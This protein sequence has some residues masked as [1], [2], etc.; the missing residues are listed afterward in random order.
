M[1]NQTTIGILGDGQL[2][3]MMAQAAKKINFELD[4]I[5]T[6]KL[7]CYGSVRTSPASYESDVFNGNYDD[8]ELLTK[9]LAKNSI[10][11]YETENINLTK[12]KQILSE[13]NLKPNIEILTTAQNRL[14]EKKMLNNLNIE[15]TEY[16]P[17]ES[18]E[19][20]KKASK[21]F[22]YKAILKTCT[23][24][25][26]GKGQF[27]INNPNSI[28][29]IW[30]SALKQNLTQKSNQKSNQELEINT[31]LI[32]E[33]LVEFNQELSI[34][35]ARDINNNIKFYPLTKNI[36]Q[37]GIL[38]LSLAP[39]QYLSSNLNQSKLLERQAQIIIAKIL[40]HFDYIGILCV[41]FFQ[42]G[43]KLV[44]N[45]IA[46][47]VHNSGHWTIEGAKTS[48]FENHLRAISGMPLGDTSTVT[49]SNTNIYSAMFNFIS[50]IPTLDK[51]EVI[52]NLVNSNSNSKSNNIYIH[53]YKKLPRA[54][55]KLGHM[56]IC[57]ENKQDLYHI[58]EQVQQIL[59]LNL[60][61]T[62]HK[63]L[64]IHTDIQTDINSEKNQ[65]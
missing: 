47:R 8:L 56:N 45:E 52:K 10:L 28:E 50:K 40:Q 18:L 42:V 60:N 24:G 41:E 44:V 53:D 11:T 46:P 34:I 36:H 1:S 51:I 32:L 7:E 35:A 58:I 30:Q 13:H 48:Q 39:V 21:E 38:R 17:I 9:F 12:I 29:T 6:L 59:N 15:T 16:R 54:N 3:M 43:D 4:N 62:L 57:C 37:N 61:L 14:L 5:N 55:R 19:S 22:K 63:S 26:D 20:L 49:S 2:A 65:S 27:V 25:Y 33:K 64:D 31:N 23:A